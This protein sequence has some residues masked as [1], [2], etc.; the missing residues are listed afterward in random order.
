MSEPLT[1]GILGGMGPEATNRLCA[2]VT[3]AT[4]AHA[5]QDH[6]PV[7]TYNN[8]RIPPRVSAVSGR[9]ESPAPELCR[10]A[11]V[12]ERAG[13]HMILM[14]CNLAHFFIAEV[15]R[16]VRVPVLDMIAE[17]AA[18]VARLRPRCRRAGLL[19]STPTIRCGLYE[20]AFREHGIETVAPAAAAQERKVMR[21][22][23]GAE[24]IKGGRK[25]RPRALLKEAA[26]G[27]A[28]DGAELIVAGCTEVPLVLAREDVRVPLVDPL[29]VVARVAVR[30]ALGGSERAGGGPVRAGGASSRAG[31]VGVG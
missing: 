20:A 23:Y 29:E 28:A 3:A 12:L 26:E 18:F 11:R 13:A 30:H 19:A 17:T 6:V 1:I 10:T 21:A 16:A 25:T 9:G 15:Q 8:P 2:L 5:D 31:G 4:P 22:I 14:P 7:I 27:L 24:G